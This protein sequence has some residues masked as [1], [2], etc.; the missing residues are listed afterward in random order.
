MWLRTSTNL[1]S[2]SAASQGPEPVGELNMVE[3]KS[4]AGL[5]ED[6]PQRPR[7]A[8]QKGLGRGITGPADRGVLA[9]PALF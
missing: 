1:N 6:L 5:R 9:S 7:R 4:Q 2:L 3:I 8:E